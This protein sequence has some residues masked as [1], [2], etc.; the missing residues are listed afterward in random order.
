MALSQGQ[1]SIIDRLFGPQEDKPPK[2]NY[3]S[4]V[5]ND[6]GNRTNINQIRSI[7]QAGSNGS[8]IPRHV[9]NVTAAVSE[10]SA[11]ATSKI[12]LTFRR[13]STDVSFGGVIVYARGYQGNQSPTQVGFGTDAPITV[14]LNNTG[15]SVSLIVQATGNGGNAPLS[16]AP[17]CGVKLPTSTNGGFGTNT[18]TNITTT[19][20][21][22]V[23]AGVFPT[24]TPVNSQNASFGGGA[25]NQV[26]TSASV[27]SWNVQAGDV[28]AMFIEASFGC[29][30]TTSQPTFTVTDD[31]GN[32]WVR[33]G[34][35]AYDGTGTVGNPA[36][37]FI[38]QLSI[39]TWTTVHNGKPL[40][41]IT[42][43]STVVA[44]AFDYQGSLVL[45]QWRLASNLAITGFH[46]KI[47]LSN[48]SAPALDAFAV[49]EPSLII[50]DCASAKAF[51]VS[52]FS[53]GYA[54][55]TGVHTIYT[56]GPAGQYQPTFNVSGAATSYPHWLL[57][58]LVFGISKGTV[59]TTGEPASGNLAKFSGPSS[60]TNGDLSGDVTTSGTLATTLAASG[61]AA[62]SY[63][64]ANITVDAKGRVTAAATGS[65]GGGLTIDW[66]NDGSSLSG[67]TLG[68]VA[69]TISDHTT[70]PRLNPAGIFCIVDATAARSHAW[71]DPGIALAGKTI[72]VDVL[73]PDSTSIGYL[74][75]GVTSAGT[76]NGAFL[77]GRGGLNPG[78][79]GAHFTSF[80]ADAYVDNSN[81]NNTLLDKLVKTWI[82]LTVAIDG[83]GANA[84]I[85]LN[86]TVWDKIPITLTST[87]IAVGGSTVG[88]GAYYR[89][90]FIG[91]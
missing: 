12:V 8:G 58:A 29:T 22:Q 78:G 5:L 14:I 63:T 82:R 50:A 89:N 13:D 65:S 33:Q 90:F 9:T 40:T 85:S 30:T 39:S 27:S 15:E 73:I 23:I 72:G 64:N 69:P 45:S 54:L 16:T 62:G 43:T 49:D 71:I 67:W 25:G 57:V 70:N 41:S 87:G 86:G 44:D 20:V 60:I 42:A 2:T 10:A 83:G 68:A 3:I 21:Q 59:T 1:M 37:N 36:G 77:D 38:S 91:H 11:G 75:F 66:S 47:I 81:L 31:A 28:L 84:T 7:T 17:T 61:V 18:K 53:Q 79:V 74:I 80:N 32:V 52:S 46:K 26:N 35:D 34:A 6:A 88:A 51:S 24:P 76:G 56:S 55:V 19:Q 4:T 48:T